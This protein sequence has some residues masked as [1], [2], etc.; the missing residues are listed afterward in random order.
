MD[1]TLTPHAAPAHE[2]SLARARDPVLA[3][4][5]RGYRPLDAVAAELEL[6]L[7]QRLLVRLVVVLAHLYRVL[8]LPLRRGRLRALDA[9]LEALRGLRIRTR[10]ERDDLAHFPESERR[11]FERDGMLGPFEVMPPAEAVA[12]AGRIRDGAATDFDGEAVLGGALKETLERHGAWNLQM[13]AMHRGLR[14]PDVRDVMRRPA[15]AERLAGILGDEVLCWR[16]QFFE[17]GPGAGGTFWHQTSTFRE[18]SAASKLEPTR[19]MDEAIV[20]LTVWTALTEVTVANGALRIVPGSFTDGRV[21]HLYYF[22]KDN[23]LL[24]FAALLD[25]VPTADIATYV[26]IA[27]YAMGN[28]IRSQTVLEAVIEYLGETPFAGRSV[29]DLE[30]RP[31]EAVIFTSLNMHGSYPNITDDETRLALV[32][33]CAANHVRVQQPHFDYPTPEGTVACDLPPVTCFQ[34]HGQDS[35]GLNRLLPD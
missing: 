27:R 5:L 19:P 11:A 23:L 32:G 26:A 22:V 24:F 3:E 6:S 4:M 31:G 2:R 8:V 35:H 12:L 16:T 28:F 20:Q 29:R 1:T 14:D 34:V 10:G 25:R 9:E 17:K 21:E 18:A 15:V 33:R 30:L 7:R 13:A